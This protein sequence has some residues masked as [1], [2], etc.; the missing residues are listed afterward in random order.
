MLGACHAQGWSLDYLQPEHPLQQRITA[1]TA[2]WCD[3]QPDIAVDGC[4]VPTFVL[5][6]AGMARAWGRLA[7]VTADGHFRGTPDP[8]GQRIGRAICAHPWFTSGD[9]RI[10]LAV[11]RRATEPLAG[12][13]GAEGVFCISLPRRR[14]GIAI[15]VLSGN[16]DALAVAIPAVID[17]AA[18]GALRPAATWPWEDVVNVVGRRVGTRVVVLPDGA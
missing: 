1:L 2:E 6:I 12:K 7:C 15:K 18:P 16:E 8:R 17:L 11:S 14:T 5:S 9:E 3:E 10:D 4:G 13:I